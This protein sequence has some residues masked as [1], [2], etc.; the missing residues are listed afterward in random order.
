MAFLA[1]ASL[2]LLP[3]LADV[4]SSTSSS[5]HSSHSSS[6]HSSAYGSTQV[7]HGHSKAAG[8]PRDSHG[9]IQ[10]SEHA[11][12]DFKKSQPCPSTGKSSGSC[13]GYVIDHVMLL[14]CSSGSAPY[15]M[16]WQIEAAA[17]DQVRWKH[18]SSEMNWHE[19][20]EKSAEGRT[21]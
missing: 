9:K 17:K 12:N 7:G 14:Q 13:P 2:C 8:L 5:S 20:T 21:T 18:S 10:R 16:Q 6:S 19:M 1:A 4:R 15:K 11:K 3:P